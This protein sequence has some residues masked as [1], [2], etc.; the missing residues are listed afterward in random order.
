VISSSS[1][2][3]SELLSEDEFELELDEEEFSDARSSKEM[4]SSW[5]TFFFP[6]SFAAIVF[7]GTAAGGLD[8]TALM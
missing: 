8:I 6:L 1:E 7:P 2:S 4:K 5:V 3:E